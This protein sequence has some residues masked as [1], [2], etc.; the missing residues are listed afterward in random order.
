MCRSP[1][2]SALIKVNETQTQ[3]Q[4]AKF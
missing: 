1:V 4:M 3:L 2:L